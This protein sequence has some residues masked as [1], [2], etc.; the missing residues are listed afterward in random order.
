MKKQH[1]TLSLKAKWTGLMSIFILIT[2]TLFVILF[3]KNT[4]NLMIKEGKERMESVINNIDNYLATSSQVLTKESVDSAFKELF[5]GDKLSNE[6][7]SRVIENLSQQDAYIYIYDL[8]KKLIFKTTRDNENMATFP[9]VTL[10]KIKEVNNI[11]GYISGRPIVS[12][13]TGEIIGYI[14]VFYELTNLYDI[15]HDILQHLF[16]FIIIWIALVFAFDLIISRMVISPIKNLTK[17]IDKIKD[18]P[19]TQE[20]A[21]LPKSKDEIYR[22]TQMF[23]DMLDRMH[24]Y[25]DQQEEFVSDVSHELR[26]PIAVV[27]G[28]LKMLARWGK[29]DPEILDES[30]K[31]SI[32][33][34]ERMENLVQEM[35]DLSRLDQ[36]E[37]QH[38]D[39]V[40]NSKEI[41]IQVVNNFKLLYPDFVFI[42]DD[43]LPIDHEITIYRNH[44]EQ[45]LIIILDNAIKYSKLDKKQINISISSNMHNVEIG[46]QDF[47][48]GISDENLD[49]IFNRFYR[50]DKSRSREKG[51]NGLGLSIAQKL[52]DVYKGK[53]NVESSLGQ[54]TIFKIEIPINRNYEE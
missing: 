46:I 31:A 10:P 44:Y 8:N 48:L 11:S 24:S 6:T 35:L 20:R 39:E 38:L 54:G 51:G 26:T 18:N 33:E 12:D 7:E 34:I 43:D 40:C 3:Y 29:D 25:I 14:Q 28:H 42:F 50:V 21:E 23:N 47:G 9:I 16:I 45:L 49:K 53:L 32:Q 17:T 37:L 4:S 41:L 52:I 2:F 27:E 1:R 15:K 19:L 13:N 30:I 5:V 22:L 36:K